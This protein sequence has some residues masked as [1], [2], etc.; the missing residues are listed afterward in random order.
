MEFRSERHIGDIL[1]ERNIEIVG[2]DLA[3]RHGFKHSPLEAIELP[4]SARAGIVSE[5]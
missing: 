3:T 2:A 4:N 5:P 1:K